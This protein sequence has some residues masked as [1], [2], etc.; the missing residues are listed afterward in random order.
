MRD[1]G[2]R[3]PTPSRVRVC[4]NIS[5]EFLSGHNGSG[6][7]GVIERERTNV[8]DP[9]LNT[10]GVCYVFRA[11]EAP[12]TT[13]NIWPDEITLIGVEPVGVTS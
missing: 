10:P 2:Q 11:D 12:N 9:R 6:C 5:T 13:F 4:T 8:G 3:F 7:L 1:N